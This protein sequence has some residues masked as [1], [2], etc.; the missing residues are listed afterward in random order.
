M[1]YDLSP[2]YFEPFLSFLDRASE[3]RFKQ[4]AKHFILFWFFDYMTVLGLTKM[5]FY[6][7]AP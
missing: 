5:Q 3:K 2:C 1:P 4:K 7:M 6:E